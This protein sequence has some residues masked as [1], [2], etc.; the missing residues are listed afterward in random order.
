MKHDT[1]GSLQAVTWGTAPQTKEETLE[2][3]RKSPILYRSFHALSDS[4]MPMLF[5]PSA[6]PAIPQT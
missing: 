1:N 4:W 3:L 5:Q 6:F 2:F